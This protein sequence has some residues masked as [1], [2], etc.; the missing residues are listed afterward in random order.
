MGQPVESGKISFE[1]PD[2]TAPGATGEIINGHYELN[3]ALAP[4]TGTM[5]VRF[6][7]SRKTGKKLD[8]NKLG[9]GM[10]NTKGDFDEQEMYIPSMHNATS[11]HKVEISSGIMNLFDFD[12]EG[13]L[14][15][16]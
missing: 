4:G 5:I 12:L 9:P 7:A 6:W 2:A 11:K 3:G 14:K 15:K 13:G 1:S 16:K 8:P 10:D